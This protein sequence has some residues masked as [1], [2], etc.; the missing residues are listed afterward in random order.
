MF[1]RAQRRHHKDRM[2]AKA[3][4]V[5]CFSWGYSPRYGMSAADAVAYQKKS[6]K[7]ADHLAL[8]SRPGCCGNPRPLGNG[9]RTLQ[10][11]RAMRVED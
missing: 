11:K 4:R 10:E 7:W 3:R 1:N 5:A 2:K 6:E 9:N 8:C